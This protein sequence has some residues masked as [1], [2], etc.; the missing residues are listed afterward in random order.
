MVVVIVDGAGG[1]GGGI[2]GG[3][4]VVVVDVVVVVWWG[5]CRFRAIVVVLPLFLLKLCVFF[6]PLFPLSSPSCVWHGW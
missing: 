4:G 3:R 1:R 5:F 6:F 2:R